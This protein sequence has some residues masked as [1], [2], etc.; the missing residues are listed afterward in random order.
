MHAE[1]ADASA[2]N[3]M[4][5]GSTIQNAKG[6]AKVSQPCIR[7][8][9]AQTLSFGDAPQENSLLPDSYTE[10]PFCA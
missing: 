1:G 4:D 3:F 6:Q 9:L 2:Q 8:L 10:A 7:T 5:L